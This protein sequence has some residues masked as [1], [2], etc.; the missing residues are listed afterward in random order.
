MHHTIY[1]QRGP[2]K[3]YLSVMHNELSASVLRS[4][5]GESPIAVP[6][7]GETD[8]FKNLEGRGGKGASGQAGRRQD[9]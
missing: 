8:D 1:A 3:A 2:D 9:W 7:S 5:D 6:S 4:Q